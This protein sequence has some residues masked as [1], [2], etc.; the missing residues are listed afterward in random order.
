VQKRVIKK[1]MGSKEGEGEKS[2]ENS[3]EDEL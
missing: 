1:P 2:G 3:T